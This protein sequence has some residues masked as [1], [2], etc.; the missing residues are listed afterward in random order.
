M[1]IIAHEGIED[2]LAYRNK[3][4]GLSG[5]DIHFIHDYVLW[6]IEDIFTEK[7]LSQ[8]EIDDAMNLLYC[9]LINMHPYDKDWVYVGTGGVSMPE[10]VMEIT[11]SWDVEFDFWWNINKIVVKL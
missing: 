2:S 10:W 6:E 3:L 9:A 8:D 4:N 11:E 7:L 1:W 5:D